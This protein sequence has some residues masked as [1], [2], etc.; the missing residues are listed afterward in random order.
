[1][2]RNVE[3]TEKQL[4]YALNAN[5]RWNFAVGA[6]RSG[7]SHLAVTHTIP[8]RVLARRGKKGINLILGAT[9]ENIERNV[10]TPMRD[11]YGERLVGEIRQSTGIAILFGEKVYCIGAES[12]DTANKL[13][14][15][16]VKFCYCDEITDIHKDVFDLLKS[17]LSLPYSEC[18]AACNPSSP[19]HFI[20]QFIDSA[21]T[22]G[23]DLFYQ[24]YTIWDNPFLDPMYVKSLEME[25]Q[26]TVY[27]ARYIKGLWTQAEGLVW[28][29]HEQALED[30]WEPPEY[31]E[32]KF[33][34]SCDY[35]T[36]NPFAA[37][38]WA[39]DEDGIWHCVDEYYYS[40]RTEGHQKTDADYADDMERFCEDIPGIVD[41]IVDP[42]ATSFMAELRKR[43][44]FRVIP[45][46]NAVAD[47]IRDTAVAMQRGLVKIG[48]NCVSLV[49]EL[50]GYVWNEKASGDV[51]V[52]ENDHACDAMR[53]F[54]KTKRVYQPH[55]SYVS[56]F[57]M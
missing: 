47:G 16:E 38:K 8:D 18:H 55:Q 46:D 14:G 17:R 50:Q 43:K 2:S 25:Y 7:K 21:Q 41:F 37:L 56:P 34:V 33:C 51:P 31:F 45:A 1:M 4:D 32:P 30:P 48:R 28:P 9:R 40:G 53:Y 29:N 10:L 24:H 3:Y 42:S 12:R 35:G 20:K 11:F 52:K 39:T 57:G 27:Y 54:V 13:R 26:G 22:Q 44:K 23:L 19:K 5:R 49:D 15:S 6:V 36:Q